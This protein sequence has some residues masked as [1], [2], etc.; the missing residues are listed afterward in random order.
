MVISENNPELFEIL[1]A[2]LNLSDGAVV[3]EEPVFKDT[4]THV[5]VDMVIED[6]NKRYF[7]NIKSRASVNTIANLVLLKEILK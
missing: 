3:K 2:K 6:D 4:S 1:R 5:R 7:I